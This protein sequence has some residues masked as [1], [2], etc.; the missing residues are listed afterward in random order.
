MKP[1]YFAT[2]VTDFFLRCFHCVV[3]LLK[4]QNQFLKTK[5]K[6]ERFVNTLCNSLFYICN[7][8]PPSYDNNCY[9]YYYDSQQDA[10]N[11]S[12]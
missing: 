10:Q 9:K 11:I 8:P 4:I 3:Q 6:L 12:H 5:Q 7:L 2:C 1:V